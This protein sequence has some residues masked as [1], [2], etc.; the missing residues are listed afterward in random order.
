MLEDQVARNFPLIKSRGVE[1]TVNCDDNLEAYFDADLIGNII[2]NV[3]VNGCRY[4]KSQLQLNATMQDKILCFSVAD[5]GEG[6]PESM[7][8]FSDNKKFGSG[9][10]TQLGFYEPTGNNIQPVQL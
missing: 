5:D 4:T 2:Q 1:L 3:F 9:H 8:D 10:S 6:F 7:L